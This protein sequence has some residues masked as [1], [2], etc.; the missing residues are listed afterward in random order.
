[1]LSFRSRRGISSF[2]RGCFQAWSRL[3]VC[4]NNFMWSQ[5]DTTSRIR[6]THA[7]TAASTYLSIDGS[8]CLLTAVQF[9]EG[10]HE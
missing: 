3:L 4:C 1:M 9:L 2:L 7:D 10:E 6:P 5:H 8:S